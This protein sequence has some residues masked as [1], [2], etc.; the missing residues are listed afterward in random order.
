[1][2]KMPARDALRPRGDLPG[3][4]PF[5]AFEPMLAGAGEP[6]AVILGWQRREAVLR[7]LTT[8]RAVIGGVS[9]LRPGDRLL[10]EI[11]RGQALVRE[12]R[13]T[14]A[15]LSG[16]EIEHFGTGMLAEAS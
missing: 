6:C 7:M 8:T 16:I 14:G 4:A 1:M 10:L 13:V 15:S 2:T 3:A 5:P 12:G 11:R 9:G